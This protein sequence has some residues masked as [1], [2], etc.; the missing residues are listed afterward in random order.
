M[1]TS[2]KDNLYVDDL[3]RWAAEAVVRKNIMNGAKKKF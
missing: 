2:A 1:I 3:F